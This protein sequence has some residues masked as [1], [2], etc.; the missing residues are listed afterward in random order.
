LAGGS[1]RAP[2]A[3]APPAPEAAPPAPARVAGARAT[4]LFPLLL[5][6]SAAVGARLPP[7]PPCVVAAYREGS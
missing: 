7:R 5:R 1:A 2:E 4:G 6:A 3:A